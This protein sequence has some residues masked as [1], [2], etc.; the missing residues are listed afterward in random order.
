[1]IYEFLLSLFLRCKSQR[2]VFPL[3]FAYL[4]GVMGVDVRRMIG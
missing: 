3:L 2:E 4:I 1:M